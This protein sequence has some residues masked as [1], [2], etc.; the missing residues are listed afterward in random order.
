MSKRISLF[1]LFTVSLGC[2]H[3]TE[4]PEIYAQ[5][6]MAHKSSDANWE[7]TSSVVL[8]NLK[9]EVRK[10]AF[11]SSIEAQ[12]DLSLWGTI[13]EKN[14]DLIVIVGNSMNY[15]NFDNKLSQAPFK[16]LEES[17]DFQYL[18]KQIPIVATWSDLD[19]GLRG[20]D[21]TYPLKNEAK[22]KF[23]EYWSYILPH[24]KAGTEGI[25]HALMFGQG[26]SKLQVILLD[27]RFYADEWLSDRGNQSLSK[28]WNP[29]ATLLGSKQWKWLAEQLDEPAKYRLIISPLPLGF[30]SG[31]KERWA[32]LP[33]ER[34]K[35]FDTVR[36]SGS[37]NYIIVSAGEGLGNVSKVKLK[38][39]PS[40]Y[41]FS[42][43]SF[44]GA[45]TRTSADSN[46]DQEVIHENHFGWLELNAEGPVAFSFIG[47]QGRV[48]R[49][50]KIVHEKRF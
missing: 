30:K 9:N 26:D 45:L 8:E 7:P 10:I 41:D 20:G 23:L 19:Y 42:V 28:N 25:E 14:P 32:L 18:K 13:R 6:L 33:Y 4:L 37:A 40:L 21:S 50:H 22:E 48:L 34:Q 44:N 17:A 1:I 2:A 11:V 49:T 43:G 5:K 31:E 47:H 46:L 24:Q 3:Q 16:K 39:F 15:S 35:F 38:N 36:N 12:G 29:R 27:T